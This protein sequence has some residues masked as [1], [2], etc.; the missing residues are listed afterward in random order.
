[1]NVAILKYNAGNIYSVQ[2]AL[3]RLGYEAILADEVEVLETADKIIFPGV[4]E[5]SSAMAYLRQ[6][7]LDAWLVQTRKPVLGICLG[8]QLLCKFS[9]ENQTSGLNIFPVLVRRFPPNG[10]V[11]H[12]GWN[13]I[14]QLKGPLFAGVDEGAYVYFVHSY[15]P[16]LTPWTAAETE[17]L[18]SFSAA[19]EREN[20][21][22]VQFHPEKSGTVGEIILRNFL[23]L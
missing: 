21:F 9:E 11:P 7:G 12:T 5:A 2:R 15:Y 4:G 14:G 17:Y 22:G 20:F 16:E 13:T 23:E 18:V 6:R 3:N 1:M 8:L 19:I 10:K